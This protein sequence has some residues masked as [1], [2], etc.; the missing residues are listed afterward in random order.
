MEDLLKTACNI[1]K[2]L[3]DITT[4]S[5][6]RFPYMSE[7]D[8]SSTPIVY[9]VLITSGARP[10]PDALCDKLNPGTQVLLHTPCI[11]ESIKKVRFLLF[12]KQ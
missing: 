8:G 1:G 9:K 2:L 3:C 12:K 10:L 11:Y 5:E 7:W 4:L 6:Q